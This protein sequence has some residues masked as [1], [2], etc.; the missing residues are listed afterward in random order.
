ML[1]P[2]LS[3]ARTTTGITKSHGMSEIKP[4]FFIFLPLKFP[5][6]IVTQKA[7]NDNFRAAS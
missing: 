4:V 1:K 5:N 7:D 2:W 3:A 6:T